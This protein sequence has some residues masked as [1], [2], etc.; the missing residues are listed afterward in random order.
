MCPACI[1]TA[2]SV[3]ASVVAVTGA[4]SVPIRWW[5]HLRS[6][7]RGLFPINSGEQR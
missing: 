3:A 7:I 6:R 4:V 2:A 5:S 1:S